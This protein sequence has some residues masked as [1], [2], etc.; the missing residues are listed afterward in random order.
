MVKHKKIIVKH[1]TQ[2]QK[3]LVPIKQNETAQKI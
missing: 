3:K 2:K 1:T